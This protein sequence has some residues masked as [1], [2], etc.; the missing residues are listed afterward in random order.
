MMIYDQLEFHNVVELEEN[1]LFPG[2]RLHRYPRDV[3][4][5][6]STRGSHISTQSS[7]CEIRFVTDAEAVRLS[8][9]S[10]EEDGD[11]IVFKGDY[12]HSNHR[13]QAGVRRTLLLEEPERFK[14]ESP[15]RKLAEESSLS[16]SPH[17]WRIMTCRYTAVFHELDT[18]GRSVRPPHQNEVPALRW[19]AYGSSITHG[20][21]AIHYYNC[22]AQQAARRLGVDV[23]NLG[24]S[25]SCLCEKE[26]A[27]YIANRNDWDIATLELGVNMRTLFTPEQF[28]ERAYYLIQTVIQKQ[29]QKPVV[30]ITVYPNAATYSHMDYPASR[31]ETQFNHILR[32]IVSELDHSSLYLIEGYEIMKD[33]SSLVFDL[34]HPSDYGHMLMG[35]HLAAKLR[36]ILQVR[37]EKS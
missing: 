14:R 37:S 7:G 26:A 12:F 22:Y 36:E 3:R 31:N 25:G 33:M 5:R 24:L 28:K 17:V 2:L 30:V 6:L 27:D 23:L 1:K 16:F 8:I 35:E 18:L 11:L 9:S 21:A 13:L 15:D 32:E 34:L 29:P 19:L 4:N 20:G 10:L